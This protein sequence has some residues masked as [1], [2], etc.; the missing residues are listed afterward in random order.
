[1]LKFLNEC[2]KSIQTGI[3]IMVV[4]FLIVGIYCACNAH[5]NT[6]DIEDGHFK[7]IYDNRDDCIKSNLGTGTTEMCDDET[8]V[9][10]RDR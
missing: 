3:A 10:Y 4:L 9:I 2:I 1:M 5:G 7:S 6:W 8:Q